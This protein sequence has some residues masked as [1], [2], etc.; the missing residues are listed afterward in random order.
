MSK[1]GIVDSETGNIQQIEEISAD[2][3]YKLLGIDMTISG[4]FNGQK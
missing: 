1:L 2:D 4:K 3:N